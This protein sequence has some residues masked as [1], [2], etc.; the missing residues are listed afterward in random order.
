MGDKWKTAISHV[1]PNRIVIRGHEI[2]DLLGKCSFSQALFLLWTGNLPSPEIGRLMDAVMIGAMDHGASPPSVIAAR[3]VAST[4]APLNAAMAAGILALDKH[5][6]AAIEACMKVLKAIVAG[7]KGIGLPLQSACSRYIADAR[8]KSVRLRIPGLGHRMHTKDPRV[9][10]IFALAK[11]C[12]VPGDYIAAARELESQMAASLGKPLP[13]NIDG[14][15]AAVFC[16]IGFPDDLANALFRLCRLTGITVQAHE[17][18]KREKPMRK[19]DA[20]A[21]EYDGPL[22]K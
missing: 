8:D 13:I 16:E 20:G 12:A 15:I 10:I 5:H 1:E 4:G 18:R 14:C 22:P 2:S 3:T 19:I 7:S 6:G 21:F 17:E 11:D 9:D